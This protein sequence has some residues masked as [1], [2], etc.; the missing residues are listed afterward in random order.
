MSWKSTGILLSLAIGL[1]AYIVIV[2][3][4]PSISPSE[5]ESNGRLFPGF[6]LSKVTE[7]G[8]QGSDFLIRA[9]R[10]D[11]AW[12]LTTPVYPAQQ[13]G[14]EAFLRSIGQMERRGSVS[15]A[16]IK[17]Q[18]TGR[19]A[20]GL[21][22]ARATVMLEA[23]TNQIEMLIGTETLFADEIYV[24]RKGASG[25]DVVEA[26][27][28][29]HL[30]ASASQ[31]RNPMLF[32]EERLSFDRVTITN[33]SHVVELRV[34][35][36]SQ[37]WTMVK[38]LRSRTE[39]GAVNSLLQSLRHARI[40]K[41]V[42]DDP[43]A[44]L[45]SFGLGSQGLDV[46]LSNGETVASRIRFGT[47]P[48]GA[49]ASVYAR[50]MSHTNIVLVP[51]K[52]A[53]VVRNPAAYF[54]NHRL[55]SLRPESTGRIEIS[56]RDSFTLER[57]ADDVWRIAKP[58][59][60]LADQE[61]ILKIFENFSRL[62][63]VEFKK[64]E[65]VDFSPF[66]LAPAQRSYSFYSKAT[67]SEVASEQLL[68]RIEFSANRVNSSGLNGVFS[69]RSDEKS[70]YSV[71]YE[72]MLRLPLTAFELRD[73]RIWSFETNQISSITV[74]EHGKTNR[75][76]RNSQKLWSQDLIVNERV[77]ETLHRLEKVRAVSWTAKGKD[78]L[79]LYGIREGSYQITLEFENQREPQVLSFGRNSRR[80]RGPYAAVELE[81]GEPVIFVF[82]LVL[83][84]MVKRD[85]SVP[86][87]QPEQ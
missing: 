19:S 32:P 8:V 45:V 12:T 76:T 4:R 64:D 48:E 87:E 54:R 60:A 67:S 1:F 26:S 49:P 59:E 15:A 36:V 63:I 14:I 46:I 73:K 84:A 47:S 50:L 28:L 58:F 24:Q 68:V 16:D 72:E 25:I 22:P 69:R 20:F 27:I 7:I 21:D 9:S 81:E 30:P 75:F 66:G 70:V 85:F 61:A 82:P 38:P 78:K 33:T 13:A 53:E 57:S 77:E 6:E 41:F 71:L 37:L 34:D 5:S 43:N 40:T 23:G 79:T 62:Q 42:T 10:S 17:A 11:G 44:D 51:S 2:E 65:V 3:L 83:S 86:M 29:N 31:W 74:R 39:F 56:T 55:V 80:G 52:I 35:P 18:T